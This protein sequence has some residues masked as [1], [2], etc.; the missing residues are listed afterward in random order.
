MN[1]LILMGSPR[2]RGNT[3]ELCKHT[4]LE[5]IGMYSV[6]DND[7]L[8]SF[9]TVEAVEGTKKFARMVCGKKE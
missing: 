2:L 1:V 3:A 5:Y 8:A 7:N 6:Q 4:N 9:Q